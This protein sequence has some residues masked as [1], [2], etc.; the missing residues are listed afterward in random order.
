MGKRISCTSSTE[1]DQLSDLQHGRH[2]G[3]KSMSSSMSHIGGCPFLASSD[4]AASFCSS[5]GGVPIHAPQQMIAVNKR[6]L[7]KK[8][9][10]EHPLLPTRDGQDEKEFG[11]KI[12][13]RDEVDYTKAN[14]K[15]LNERIAGWNSADCLE[16]VVSNLVKTLEMELTKKKDPQQWVSMSPE[17]FHYRANCN[18]YV[19]TKE[20]V[21]KG[22]YNILMSGADKALYD[23]DMGFEESHATFSK[24]FPG[25][26][27]LE[28]LKVYGGPPEIG[29]TWRH[30]G[31]FEGE[32]NGLKG[33]GREINVFGF[34]RAKVQMPT[35]KDH[36][37]R[38]YELEVFYDLDKFLAELNLKD[39]DI[40]KVDT[41]MGG[42]VVKV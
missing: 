1:E 39:V 3:C 24:A 42:K 7:T 10:A 30:W 41:L 36:R 35:E 5:S 4:A 31:T 34:G 22:S 32:Y 17:T 33:D 8:Q 37:I 12:A 27:A 20:A 2:G 40:T 25:G 19:E 28:I 21:E 38:I 29:F 13:W 6:H 14:A 9:I 16:H 15:Y 11:G 23:V 26:F 18:K